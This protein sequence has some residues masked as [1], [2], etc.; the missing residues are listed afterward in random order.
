MEWVVEASQLFGVSF[1]SDISE[2][3]SQDMFCVSG[4][5]D[6]ILM[7]YNIYYDLVEAMY[8][9]VQSILW[10]YITSKVIPSCK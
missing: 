3:C 2:A 4:Q 8:F 6:I 1:V 5:I 7:L 9:P 10:K